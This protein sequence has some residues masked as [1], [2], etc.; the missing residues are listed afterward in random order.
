MHKHEGD[1]Y[2]QLERSHPYGTTNILVPALVVHHRH[3]KEHSQHYSLKNISRALL[4]RGIVQD[5]KG[6]VT[7]RFD[8]N[9]V[10]TWE[11]NVGTLTEQFD[12]YDGEKQERIWTIK[13][14]ADKNYEGSAGDIIGTATGHGEGHAMRWSYQMDLDVKDNT[15]RITF[16]DW[17]FLMND[18]VLI[19][20]S[21]LKKLVLQWQSTIFMQKQDQ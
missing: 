14:I 1:F 19:N 18:G 8:I 12:Y 16:D 21:Y 4:K 20:R 6:N 10:G 15:Y 9:M 2:A 11:D 5:R 7:R 13:K 17:M 3:S